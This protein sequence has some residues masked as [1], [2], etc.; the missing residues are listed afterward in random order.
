MTVVNY[1]FAEIRRVLSYVVLVTG[2]HGECCANAF[3]KSLLCRDSKMGLPE[4]EAAR[5]VFKT[6]FNVILHLYPGRFFL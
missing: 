5:I 3:F 4:Y 2:G 6:H 1:E